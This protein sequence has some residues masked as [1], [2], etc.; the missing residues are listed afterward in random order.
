MNTTRLLKVLQWNILTYKKPLL[1][2]MLMPVMIFFVV[3]MPNFINAIFSHE[4]I[5][6]DVNKTS[7][8]FGTVST[9]LMLFWASRVCFNQQTK[10]SYL[11]YAMLPATM[12][13]KF[14]ANV[15]F[16]T[17]VKVV[18]LIAAVVITDIL[19]SAVSFAFAG[20]AV[21]L[22]LCTLQ[23]L[24]EIPRAISIEVAATEA[25]DS[26]SL[27]LFLHSLFVLGGCFFRRHHFLFTML[28]LISV[29]SIL[30]FVGAFGLAGIVYMFNTNGYSV[31]VEPLFSNHTYYILT[32]I[33]VFILSLLC[34]WQAYRL[35]RRSQIINNRFF[36]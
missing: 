35:F 18:G 31:S 23:N 9:F 11:S 24:V 29:P 36:N 34:Y 26:L 32:V 33:T 14:V 1:R 19:L 10:T 12:V 28:C 5:Y 3:A 15:L 6:H 20:D 21:S 27:T 8:T 30:T 17:V 22:T 4:V 16:Q 25:F 7:L 2:Q 13:E